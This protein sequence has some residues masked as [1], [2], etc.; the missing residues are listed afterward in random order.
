MADR[1]EIRATA[2]RYGW[3]PGDRPT[4][5]IVVKTAIACAVHSTDVWDALRVGDR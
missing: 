3:H 1:D 5:T 2:E 4:A